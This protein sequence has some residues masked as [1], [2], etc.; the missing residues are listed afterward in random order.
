MKPRRSKER[1][2]RVVTPA[3]VKAECVRAAGAFHHAPPIDP[4]T[5]GACAWLSIL[6][7]SAE[8]YAEELRKWRDAFAPRI[9]EPAP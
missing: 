2:A 3:D 7:V 1:A 6:A 4:F 9:A 8:L 5:R